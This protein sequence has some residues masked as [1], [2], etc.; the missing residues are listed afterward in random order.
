[1]KPRTDSP[2]TMTPP[3]SPQEDSPKYDRSK[4]REFLEGLYLKLK[5]LCD[6]TQG[7]IEKDK[8][9][10][11]HER[12]CFTVGR[13]HHLVVER[14]ESQNSERPHIAHIP[15]HDQLRGCGT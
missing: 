10:Y 5:G 12:E 4:V 15:M 7:K 9:N 8:S 11:E 1:M 3:K 2:N 14:E 13:T 6:T